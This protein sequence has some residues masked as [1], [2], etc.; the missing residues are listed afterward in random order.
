[1]A[2]ATHSGPKPDRKDKQAAIQVAD[3]IR[4]SFWT[5]VLATVR[6]EGWRAPWMLMV[7]HLILVSYPTCEVLFLNALKGGPACDC[8]IGFIRT[9]MRGLGFECGLDGYFDARRKQ[10]CFAWYKERPGGAEP[11]TVLLTVHHDPDDIDVKDIYNDLH[12]RSFN[13]TAPNQK[14]LAVVSAP[15]ADGRGERADEKLNAALGEALKMMK[16]RVE[17]EGFRD[18][19]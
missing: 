5:T 6:V 19:T 1:M 10:T 11:F 16:A 8:E 13:A 2:L 3:D 14:R 17:E 15:V 7:L 4:R 9:V 18:N 12:P